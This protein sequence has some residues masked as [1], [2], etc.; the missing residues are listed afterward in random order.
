VN[1][2]RSRMFFRSGSATAGRT[3]ERAAGRAARASPV[4]SR[5]SGCG[6]LRRG[7]PGL[8]EAAIPPGVA[9]AGRAAVAVPPAVA[10]RPGASG[11]AGAL[12][13]AGVRGAAGAA[14]RAE[15][16]GLVRRAWSRPAAP[17]R[18]G[19]ARGREAGRRSLTR[20]AP[21]RGSA[22]SRRLAWSWLSSTGIAHLRSEL[23]LRRVVIVARGD[24]CGDQPNAPKDRSLP[25]FAGKQVGARGVGAPPARSGELEPG[26]GGALWGAQ[27]GPVDVARDGVASGVRR[28]NV[29]RRVARRLVAP[30]VELLVAAGGAVRCR[31]RASP[32]VPLR[33]ILRP[34]RDA[35]VSGRHNTRQSVRNRGACRPEGR[36]R[37]H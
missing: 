21:W 8:P 6:L 31:P 30:H 24:G 27:K 4:R 28:M 9:A 5:E 18:R 25:R 29:A 36:R 20:S 26:C 16:I 35:S 34:C 12:G 1:G 32:S 13:S 11:S 33:I 19:N 23:C 7:D 14:G 37:L 10:G 17:G 3:T 2:D 22:S 15:T